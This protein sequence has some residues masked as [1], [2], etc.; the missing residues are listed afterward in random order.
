MQ[1]LLAAA[2]GQGDHAHRAWAAWLRAVDIEHLEP[3]AA[4]LLGLVGRNLGELD[5]DASV[6]GRVRGVHRQTWARN[7]VLW[8]AAAPLIDRLSGGAGIPLLLPPCSLLPTYDDDW[9]VRPCERV[10]VA[11]HPASAHAARRALA[12]EGWEVDHL[13][14]SL[15][16]WTEAGFVERWESQDPSGAR[17]SIQWHV[18]HRVRSVVVDE[19]MHGASVLTRVDSTTV[20]VLHPIDALLECVWNSASLADHLW[21]ADTTR[22]AR[23]L[24]EHGSAA[25]AGDVFGQFAAR[26]RALT[27]LQVVRDRLE[28]VASIVP[29]AA[30]LSALGAL[31]ATR[32]ALASSLWTLPEPAA[33]R[34]RVL[35]GYAA[36]AGVVA[37]GRALARATWAARQL[38]SRGSAQ[39]R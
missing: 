37:G 10:T 31:R 33:R 7:R 21:V 38:R 8:A 39:R 23:R 24:A 1:L 26:A 17:V 28:L 9:G 25:G 29:D 6:E 34:G 35:A 11:L 27:V 13:T 18:L 32:P 20:H 4:E 19:R 16:A 5:A 12:E 3:G 2:V 22:L 14:L 36:G 30:V 15:L